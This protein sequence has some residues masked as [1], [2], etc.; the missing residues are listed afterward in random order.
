MTTLHVRRKLAD[1]P[2]HPFEPGKH[3]LTGNH[4]RP[5][6]ETELPL[7][8][9]TVVVAVQ[10]LSGR[11]VLGYET[12]DCLAIRL[13]KATDELVTEHFTRKVTIQ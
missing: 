1:I 5:L 7:A 9:G 8:L 4:L 2:M 12:G 3:P 11:I 13:D 6:R 10:D